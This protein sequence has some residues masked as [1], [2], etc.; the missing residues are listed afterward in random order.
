MKLEVL[1]LWSTTADHDGLGGVERYPGQHA[2]P[3]GREQFQRDTLI[4][5][6]SIVTKGEEKTRPF[7]IRFTI[8]SG[9]TLKPGTKSATGLRGGNT[10]VAHNQPR[11][12]Q[13]FSDRH[14]APASSGRIRQSIRRN[15]VSG[16]RGIRRT[17]MTWY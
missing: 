7:N 13:I 1:M 16:C 11:I 4:E 14:S 5:R 15:S 2:G 12:V 17:S 8:R 9:A 10:I 3:G 6:R